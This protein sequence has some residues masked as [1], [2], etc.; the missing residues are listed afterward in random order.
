VS[1]PERNTVGE[2]YAAYRKGLVLGLTMAEV[3][4]L[5]IF[6]L[7]LLIGYEATR[8]QR[9][10][11]Q[12][13]GLQDQQAALQDKLPIDAA[14]LAELTGAEARLGEVAKAMGIKVTRPADDF[15]RLARVMQT[16]GERPEVRRELAEANQALEEI[17]EAAQ[18]MR[19]VAGA[20]KD[21]LVKQAE[22]QSF[23]IANQDGQLKRY[24]RQLQDAGQGKGERPCWVEPDGSI[25]YLYDV[26]LGSQGI[27]MRER[28]YPGRAAERASL[29]MPQVDPEEELSGAELLRRTEALYQYSQT[30]SCRFFVIVYDG[31]GTQEKPLYKSE[32]KAVE[33]HF[34]KL[35]SAAAPPF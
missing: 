21:A 24:E 10:A 2:Q 27:R 34:Y 8:Y 29:P 32:L 11:Q 20:G 30:L 15:R 13:A 33:G 18:Q 3:G 17:K 28:I 6:V 9:L 19:S 7:L 31:T 14:R 26:V 22:A 1:V 5:I 12:L 23:R 35:L 16:A 25:D 4:I